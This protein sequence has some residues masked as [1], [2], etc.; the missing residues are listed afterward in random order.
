MIAFGEKSKMKSLK[1]IIIILLLAIFLA[2]M[3]YL[4]IQVFYPGA[5]KSKLSLTSGAIA[6]RDLSFSRTFDQEIFL[7]KFFIN[8]QKTNILELILPLV[9]VATDQAK[10]APPQEIKVK[11][12]GGGRQLLISWHLP[13]VC[14][15]CRV[16]IYRA[17]ENSS[18]N[19]LLTDDIKNDYYIDSGVQHKLIYYYQLQTITAQGQKSNFSLAIKAIPFDYLPP[20]PPTEVQVTDL[21]DGKGLK[22]SWVQPEEDDF[23]HVKIYRSETKGIKGEILVESVTTTSYLDSTILPDKIY[24]Y[25][26]VSV[27]QA[28]NESL[29]VLTS[30]SGRDN[31]FFIPPL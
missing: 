24:Y 4:I 8:S 15:Q 12:L 26:L 9:G 30:T 25:T 22:L 14:P 21:Q 29:P 23:N 27:D 6:K 2:G 18:Q 13:P 19:Q 16:A 31:P 20:R 11:N 10:P 3:V 7:K 1:I 5:A 17:T 28:N